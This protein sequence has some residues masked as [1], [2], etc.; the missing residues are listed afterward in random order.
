[1]INEFLRDKSLS[2]L[3]MIAAIVLLFVSQFFDYGDGNSAFLNIF[4]D[5]IGSG[6]GINFGLNGIGWELH[7]LAYVIVVVL[8]FAF[9]RSDI[10]DH[11]F[12]QKYGW[13]I[14][15]ALVVI[16]NIPSD[17]IRALGSTL[18]LF[19]MLL[20]LV[21]AILHQMSRGKAKP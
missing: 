10:Y 17:G 5:F 8:A 4:P 7:P 3:L 19:A 6:L 18:G 9:L 16:C 21:A 1:M 20:A 15:L 14:G 11:P 2:H 12:M 13:W